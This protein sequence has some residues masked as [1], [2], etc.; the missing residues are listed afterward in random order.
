[1]GLAGGSRPG[2]PLGLGRAAAGDGPWGRRGDGRPRHRHRRLADG[3]SQN[4]PD[5]FAGR[6]GSARYRE[7]VA[8]G[9]DV[10][11]GEVYEAIRIRD[12]LDSSREVSPL[13]KA[14]DAVEIDTT[15][16][17]VE[18][19]T[20]RIV[21]LCIERGGSAALRNRALLF[22]TLFFLIFR[23]RVEGVENIP[24]TGGV[25]L[26]ANHASYLDP[27]LLGSAASRP[28]H[29]MAKAELFKF[30]VLS[31]ALPRVKAFPVRRGA[32]DRT[33]IR[34]AIELLRQGEVVGIFPE[35]TR[36]PTGELLPPQRGA[37]LIAL[38][39]G[40][41]VVPVALVGT[42]R[43]FQ[44][45]KE[46]PAYQPVRRPL[47]RNHR[48]LRVRERESK[49]AVDGINGRMMQEIEALLD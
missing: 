49:E 14:E 12:S 44:V 6:E 36:T 38:R 28:V 41:P 17:S 8:R 43:P 37:G 24:Q 21:A 34:T 32:A 7:I 19:V 35:G 26:V 39:A 42:F 33:A 4:I 29:F 23:W 22:R 31:W 3:R 18:E 48:C 47:W 27:P 40:V 11:Y 1:M 10:S 5:R 20:R 46:A 15:G 30:P 9:E 45:S 2:R 25:L 13:R 16:L